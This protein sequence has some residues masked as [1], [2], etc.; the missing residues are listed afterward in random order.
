MWAFRAVFLGG[1]AWSLPRF[2]AFL[3]ERRGEARAAWIVTPPL[4][5]GASLLSLVAVSGVAARALAAEVS[6][7]AS[8]ALVPLGVLPLL[9]ALLG[10]VRSVAAGLASR[11]REPR[12]GPRA[13]F[14]A[15]VSGFALGLGLLIGLGET[16]G[17][18]ALEIMGV[19]RRQELD[20]RAPGLLLLMAVGGLLV[21]SPRT[22][23]G[24]ALAVAVLL[25]PGWLTL[26][27]AHGA[28]L[29]EPVALAIE[30]H[31][32]LGRIALGSPTQRPRSR[33]RE[34]GVRW[35]R[36]RR[37]RRE[38]EPARGRRSRQRQ[39]RRLLGR[40]CQAA[41]GACGRSRPQPCERAHGPT[42]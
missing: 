5:A 42:Q 37:S 20:L 39:G 33:R 21:K 11:L 19:L 28:T 35:R 41:D 14:V 12:F 13:A 40:R 1:R 26:K 23:G 6:G 34:R 17:G 7:A 32:P 30:R 10:T 2:W 15:S 36:L 3:G 18:G 25:A 16:G 38:R 4:V 27:A 24:F 22:P 29:S 31:A 9:L 8:F